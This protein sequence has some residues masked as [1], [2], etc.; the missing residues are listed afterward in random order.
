MEKVV[1]EDMPGRVKGFNIENSDG[2]HT[3]FINAKLNYEQ[4]LQVY[5]HEK[6]HIENNDFEKENIDLVEYHAHLKR[7][8]I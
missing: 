5:Y 7:R 2:S 4:A 8:C 3:I 6:S 1:Y